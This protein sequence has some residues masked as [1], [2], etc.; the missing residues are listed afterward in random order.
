[1]QAILTTFGIDWRLLIINALNFGILLFGLWYFLYGPLTKMLEERRS[2][3]AQ[4]VKDA[5][6]SQR[7]LRDIESKRAGVLSAAGKEADTLI[8]HAQSRA[9]QKER[10][11]LAHAEAAA[12]SVL[13]EADAQAQEAKVR[14][15]AE[16]KEE[17]A[18]LII[19][20]IE[21]ATLAR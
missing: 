1:M 16:S 21:K 4:G 18:K 5:D 20:G 2:K 6:E 3:V 13:S 17:V 8:S 9:A 11:M 7:A 14:A 10:E 15:I 12:A 19:L